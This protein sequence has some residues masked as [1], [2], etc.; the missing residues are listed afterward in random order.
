M[1]TLAMTAAPTAAPPTTSVLFA[2]GVLAR[3]LLWP[4]LRA[5][6]SSLWGGPDSAEK[7]TWMASVL[8]DAFEDTTQPTPD[9][10]YVEEQLLQIMEDEFDT[11]LEDG[12]GEAVARDVVR[13]WEAV[14][15]VKEGEAEVRKWEEQ[16]DKLKG[17]KV[18]VEVTNAA[19]EIEG[20]EG[21]WE[22]ESGDEDEM[23]EGA[24]GQEAPQLLEPQTQKV[25]PE[26][27]EDGFTLVKGKGKGKSHR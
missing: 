26:V 17:K 20:D 21:E 13:L 11:V 8:V 19:E 24:D 14:Q 9:A 23:D 3:L 18:E 1:S 7:R 6:V 16:A 10:I 27:D 25:E 4:A 2:R 15:D 12:S 5:A 22:D